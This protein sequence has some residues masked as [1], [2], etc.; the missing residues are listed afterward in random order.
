MQPSHPLKVL[1]VGHPCSPEPGSEPA[2]TWNWAW[3]LSSH[4]RVWVLA[5]PQ[6]CEHVERFLACHPNPT[7]SPV[8]VTLPQRWDPWNASRGERGIRLHY[9]LWQRAA[10]REAARLCRRCHFDLAQH[11]SWGTVSAPPLLWRLPIPFVWGP[12]GGGQ[13]APRPFRQYFG[14]AWR[15]GRSC[16]LRVCNSCPSCRRCA[17]LRVGVPSSSPPIV[18]AYRCLRRLAPVP[19]AYSWIPG[20]PRSI[21]RKPRRDG[22]PGKV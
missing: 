21:C 6:Y 16:A 13:T 14:D 12:V 19:C 20:F 11:V 3:H 2:I 1:L 18:K 5:H 10:Y 15:K 22:R 9:L 8:W 4:H 7:L 17:G